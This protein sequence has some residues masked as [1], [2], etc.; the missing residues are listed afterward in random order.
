MSAYADGLSIGRSARN[1]DV[2][3]AFLQPEVDNVV[4]WSAK[5]RLTLNSSKCVMAFLSFDCGETAWQS[6]ITIDGKQMF[7]NPFT[8]S[9]SY[10]RQLNFGDHIRKFCQ[11]MFRRI[12]LLR[13]LGGMTWGLYTSDHHQVYIAV[14]CS[15]LEYAAAAWTHS[16]SATTTSNLERVQLEAA[17]AITG[18]VRSTPVEA[19]LAESKLP[20]I[21][22]SFLAIFC[23]KAD[24]WVRLPSADECRQTIFTACRQRLKRKEWRNTQFLC[25]NQP[26]L[27]PQVLTSAPPSCEH[28][29]IPQWDKPPPFQTVMTPVDNRMSPFQQ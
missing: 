22:M 25:Q 1:N 14:V 19:V 15:M 9:V 2:I 26:G 10:D 27:N 4:D 28:L 17:R 24:L 12:N 6:S 16:L 8:I 29:S 13:A 7:C 5:A 23:L 21:S 3:I 20:P 18:L 11:L